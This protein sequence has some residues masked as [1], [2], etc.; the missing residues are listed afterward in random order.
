MVLLLNHLK[1]IP[2]K[3]ALYSNYPAI[4]IKKSNANIAYCGFPSEDVAIETQ[5]VF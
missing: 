1:Y 2:F 3:N 5:P 4:S